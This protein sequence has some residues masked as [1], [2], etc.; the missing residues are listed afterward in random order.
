[1]DEKIEN[2]LLKTS[3]LNEFS[4]KLKKYKIITKEQLS[5][6][7]LEHFNS[8]GSKQSVEQHNDPRKK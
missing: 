5:K 4:K 2:E 8:L 1:M 6:I 7:V 3:T